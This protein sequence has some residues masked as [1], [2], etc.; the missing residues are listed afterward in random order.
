KRALEARGWPKEARATL[1]FELEDEI[2]PANAGRWTLA[3]AAGKASLERGGSGG[4]A[5]DVRALAALYSGHMTARSLALAGALRGDDDAIA[6]AD[7]IFA[8]SPP[9]LVDFF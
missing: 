2:V 1:A 7:A 3:V 4:L 8:T 6:R 5:L 9:S